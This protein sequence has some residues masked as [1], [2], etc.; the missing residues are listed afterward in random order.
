MDYEKF[1]RISAGDYL[2]Q[3]HELLA[4]PVHGLHQKTFEIALTMAGAVSA[5]AYTAG[6]LDFLVEALDEWDKVRGNA[7]VPQHQVK[8]AAMSGASAGSVVA[9]VLATCLHRRFEHGPVAGNPLYQIWVN[10]VDMRDLLGQTDV[11]RADNRIPSLFDAK[12]LDRVAASALTTWPVLWGKEP[13]NVQR[14]WVGSV[15]GRPL[16]LIFAQTNLSG[17]PFWAG[18]NSGRHGMTLHADHIRF[19]LNP[20]TGYRLRED[21]YALS[22]TDLGKPEAHTDWS[23]FIQHALGSSAFP[24]G[25]AHRDLWRRRQ[26]YFFRYLPSNGPEEAIRLKPDWTAG[27]SSGRDYRYLCSDGGVTNNEPFVFAH[28]ELAGLGG[29]NPRGGQTACRAVIMIDPFPDPPSYNA[30]KGTEDMFDILAPLL[31][32]MKDQCRFDANELLLAE[33]EDIYSRFLIAPTS[34][35]GLRHGKPDKSRPLASGGLSGFS[36]FIDREYRNHD[37]ML[38]RYN[39]QRFLQQHL[40]VVPGNPYV[41]GQASTSAGEI[42]IIPL[43]GSATD[44]LSAPPWPTDTITDASFTALADLMDVR[45]KPLLERLVKQQGV[46]PC[47]SLVKWLL[48]SQHRKITNEAM[49][50]IMNDL[51][52]AGLLTHK[53]EWRRPIVDPNLPVESP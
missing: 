27:P 48:N 44:G 9:A 46:I 35:A 43:Y 14:N 16:K 26:D 19:V 49:S 3:T 24:V 17:V 52:D 41:E 7:G 47:K 23:H 34:S 42:P 40:S 12:V 11:I 18:M 4:R 51:L 38:G 2:E 32:A 37:F 6:V 10:G 8:I 1:G 30:P 31:N 22:A 5:G 45:L 13:E 20:T 36:G 33:A 25:L 53:L 21:E 29:N 15:D 50:E 39:C 28:R